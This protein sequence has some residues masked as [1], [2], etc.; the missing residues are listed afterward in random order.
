MTAVG[1]EAEPTDAE[2]WEDLKAELAA[3]RKADAATRPHLQA[4]PQR[5][6]AAG[7]GD[8]REL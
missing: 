8:L 4:S 1:L 3:R 2:R 7:Q 5:H 6:R